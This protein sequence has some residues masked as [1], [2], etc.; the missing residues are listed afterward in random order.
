MDELHFETKDFKG[1]T[2]VCEKV[3]W[4]DHIVENM[5]HK[6]MDGSE[7]DVI[8]ALRNP[9]NQY[10]CYDRARKNRRVY[11]FYHPHW[12]NYTKVVVE[13]GDEDKDCN[14]L[15]K[16]WTAYKLD[17]ITSGEKPEL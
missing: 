10:R 12:N 9:H 8:Q 2:I 17:E 6:Y 14:G 1:R 3:Q 16:V 7:E 13:F 11:Y 15:G 4:V 5:H